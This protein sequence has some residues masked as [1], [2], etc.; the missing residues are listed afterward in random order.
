MQKDFGREGISKG[1]TILAVA[2]VIV[3][4]VSGFIVVYRGT[5]TSS[6]TRS[7]T[8]SSSS[9][10]TSTTTTRD[11][12]S[13]MS[14]S[15]TTSSTSSSSQVTSC[16]SGSET[17]TSSTT[18]TTSSSSSSQNGNQILGQYPTGSGPY[19]VGYDGAPNGQGPSYGNTFEY[20]ANSASNTV[21]VY[22]GTSLVTTI[23]VG[24][25]PTAIAWDYPSNFPNNYLI[26]VT[27]SG[28][29]TV[30]VINDTS[31][32][33]MKNITVGKD[34]TAIV[35]DIDNDYSY[36][37]NSGS[38]TVSW[39]DDNTL[40]VNAT[41]PVGSDPVGAAWDDLD[42]S[43][44]G[45]IF[46]ANNKGNSVS[47]ID[48]STNT[49]IAN[50]TGV[51]SPYGLAYGGDVATPNDTLYVTSNGTSS[52]TVYAVAINATNSIPT[53]Q[54]TNITVGYDPLGITVGTVGNSSLPMA[55][56]ADY[57]NDSVTVINLNDN[58]INCTLTGIE[59][60][61]SISFN[62]DYSYV[63]VTNYPGNTVTI[64]SVPSSGSGV[65]PG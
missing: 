43:L 61:F 40:T 44:P 38:N 6:I 64:I 32:T 46:I 50:V 49:V 30:S 29:G 51:S 15:S 56:V 34:P 33:V 63:Y 52:N 4:A 10:T 21:S 62:D 58:T 18:Q 22:N 23:P 57:E 28:S 17:T 2:I 9:T 25:C 31:N 26:L 45:Y 19:G 13:T 7:S 47:V 27:N 53:F 14:S 54:V 20:I 16:S 1:L 24:L 3:I 12:S 41:I 39:I 60:P 65:R 59:N 55:Y 35:A 36:V 8:H 42:G 37:V 48:E 11:G 5:L